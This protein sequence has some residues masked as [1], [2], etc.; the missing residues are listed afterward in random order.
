MVTF[1]DSPCPAA[2]GRPGVVNY[3]INWYLFTNA[4]RRCCVSRD[5]LLALPPTL[6]HLVFNKCQMAAEDDAD[7][8]TQLRSVWHQRDHVGLY[9]A[10]FELAGAA[11][12]ERSRQLA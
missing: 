1:H 10:E 9:S 5:F 11:I 12:H 8:S 7:L 4:F 6:T 3:Q 2:C